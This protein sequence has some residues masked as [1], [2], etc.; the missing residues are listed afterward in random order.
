MAVAQG[1]E[2]ITKAF[3]G[4][5]EKKINN[6][7]DEFEASLHEEGVGEASFSFTITG[8]RKKGRLLA[9]KVTSR[10]RTPDP[11]DEFEG[12]F[13]EDGQMHFGLD[14]SE[15]V[16]DGAGEEPDAPPKGK[17]AKGGKGKGGKPRTNG[18]APSVP[19]Q[20]TA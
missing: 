14:E 2:Q 13:D 15:P 4:S 16:D 9:F 7:Y 5:I 17:G 1:R 3:I 20:P 18:R 6:R 19:D 12:Y 11:P 10:V 8:R